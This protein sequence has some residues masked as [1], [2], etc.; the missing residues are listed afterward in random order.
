MRNKRHTSSDSRVFWSM[1]KEF[2]S[3]RLPDIRKSSPNTV[4]AYRDSLN[5]FI[6][7][8]ESEKGQRRSEPSPL[9][10]EKNH[11]PH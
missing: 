9:P 6:D 2:I 5:K 8:L 7:Y 3:H 4:K 11:S 10:K 1:S